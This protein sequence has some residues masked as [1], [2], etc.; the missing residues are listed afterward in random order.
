MTS[1]L[2]LLSSLVFI[3]LVASPLAPLSGGAGRLSSIG[4]RYRYSPLDDTTTLGGTADSRAQACS[5][6]Q[7]SQDRLVTDD[8]RQV[9]IQPLIAVPSANDDVLIAGKYNYLFEESSPGRW[10]PSPHDSIFGAIL[11]SS[12]VSK[13]VVSPIPTRLLVAPKAVARPDGTWAVVFGE[14]EPYSGDDEP[15]EAARLWFGVL[16]RTGRWLNLEHIPI[17]PGGRLVHGHASSLVESDGSIAWAVQMYPNAGTAIFEWKEGEGW[18]FERVP[19]RAGIDPE[20]LYSDS[21]GLVLLVVHP[22]YS[23]K[24]GDNNSLFLWTRRPDWTILRRVV[25]GSVDGGASEPT[26]VL[27]PS[28]GVISWRAEVD[29]GEQQRSEARATVGDVLDR[30]EPIVA[31]DSSIT[32]NASVRV[33][34]VENGRPLWFID[35]EDMG[36]WRREIRFVRQS[37]GGVELLAAFPNPYNTRLAIALSENEVMLFGGMTDAEQGVAVTAV[38]RLRLDC[39][40]G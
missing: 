7:V 20:L 29:D 15:I 23:V 3:M 9:H 27:T 1:K 34:G 19:T 36:T 6:Q 32:T 40:S 37:D 26:I 35:H 21:H 24:D 38:T 31:L 14:V 22:D 4:E 11:T 5:V 25:L 17:P 30:P 33:V 28:L 12:D 18:R 10:Q 16:D 8:Q 2:I 39:P 13:I